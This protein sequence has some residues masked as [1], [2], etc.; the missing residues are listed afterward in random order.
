MTSLPRAAARRRSRLVLAAGIAASLALTACGGDEGGGGEAAGGG[1]TQ[2]FNESLTFATG[3]TGGVYYPYGGGIAN[4]LSAQVPGLT[5]TVQE[6]NAS[7]DNM[8]LLQSGQAQLALG[9]GDV[10]ADA[11]AGQNTFTEP[12]E[13]CALGNLYN[14]FVH[15]FT[16]AETGI[17][18][19]EDLRGKR[20]SPGAVGSASEVTADRIMQAAGLDPQADIERAQL[21]VAETV[22]ALQ[23]GTIDAGAWSGGLPTGAIV[24]LASTNELV[25]LPTGQY[26]ED[27]AAEYGEYYFEADI[28]AGTY[29]GVDEAVPNV[30]SPNILVVRS[31]MDE[32]LQEAIT[33][34]IFENQEQLITVHPAAEELDA[35]TAGEIG[36]IETCPGAQTYFDEVG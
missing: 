30:V 28:P 33:R 32:A 31:D 19:I 29:E 2:E 8:Q 34:T 22:A 16:T 36:F 21:G 17:T 15:F 10:V 25:L 35:T 6:T 3:G 5:V 4:V 14:N 24:D 26:A 20:V 12:L 1:D 23:D 13:I 11:A 18:S 27:L 7:V 9:L